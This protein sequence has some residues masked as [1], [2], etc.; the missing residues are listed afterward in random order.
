[1]SPVK[2]SN[3]RTV[4]LA[5]GGAVLG[6]AGVIA[7]LLF[8]LQ[9]GSGTGEVEVRLGP[10]RFDAGPAEQRARAIEAD[11]PILFSDP[12]GRDRDIYLQHLADRPEE[13]WVAFDARR[14]GTTRACTLEWQ[15]DEGHFIDPCDG[16]VIPADGEGLLHYRAEVTEEGTVVIDFRAQ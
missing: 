7:L 12:A 11:G 13:G 10:D 1:M 8:A 2:Q 14:P 4:I 9:Q 3:P 15:P 6:V 16:S 5:I